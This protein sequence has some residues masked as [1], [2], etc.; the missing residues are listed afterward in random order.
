MPDP[1][2]DDA[3]VPAAEE[4]PPAWG[5]GDVVLGLLGSTLTATVAVGVAVA[6]QGH[7]DDS[8][9]VAVAGIVGLWV[10]LLGA[11]LAAARKNSGSVARE[12]GLRFAPRDVGI[13]LVAGFGS[14]L[15]LLRLV[16]LPF[17]LFAPEFYERVGE[18]ADDLFDVASGPGLALLVL[19]VV[20]GAPL[21]EELFYRGLFQRSLARRAG[22]AWAIGVTAVVFASTHLQLASLPG[23]VAFG[24]VL[25]LLAHNDGR[26]GSAVVAHVAFNTVPVLVLLADRA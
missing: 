1:D 2:A 16:Y 7:T 8:L 18:D 14:Q 21:V 23:L 3:P 25:G 20:A 13:G 24:V 12:F 26:L 6:V 4:R 19:F 5:L 15:I 9:L 11:P 22:P 17:Q 10:G